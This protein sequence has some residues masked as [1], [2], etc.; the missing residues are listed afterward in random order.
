MKSVKENKNKMRWI[1]RIYFNFIY[2]K[3]SIDQNKIYIRNI[4]A[5]II[6]NN[7]LFNFIACMR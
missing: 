7:Y 1:K 4:S 3:K 6:I 2:K 5:I